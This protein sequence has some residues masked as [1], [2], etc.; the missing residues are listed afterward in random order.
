MTNALTRADVEQVAIAAVRV[1]IRRRKSLG[2]LEPLQRS[3]TAHGLIHPI[4]IRN[5]G[6]L[7]AGGRRLEACTRLGWKTIPARRVEAMSDDELRAIELEENTE[8]LALVEYDMSKARQAEMRQAEADLKTKAEQTRS[9]PEQVSPKAGRR[10]PAVTPG[11]RRDVAAVTGIPIASQKRI[12]DHVA[13]ADQYPFMK[14][15]AWVQHQVLHAGAELKKLPEPE[16]PKVAALLDQDGIPPREAIKVLE[17]FTEKP[18]EER[19]EILKLAQSDQP[20]ERRVALT[21]AA[22]LPDPPDDGLLILKE[23]AEKLRRAA[24]VCH[25]EALRGPLAELAENASRLAAEH[26]RRKAS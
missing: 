21:R 9:T 25:I 4:V 11:S 23:C 13:I 7:V 3:I 22:S 14:K 2:R 6:E 26:S 10:G 5:G 20:H 18:A 17:S 15:P 8:R 16:R 1:G 24:K 12:D 19:R